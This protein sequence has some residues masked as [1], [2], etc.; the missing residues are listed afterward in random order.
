MPFPATCLQ[1]SRRLLGPD[2]PCTTL[3]IGMPAITSS[4]GQHLMQMPIEMFESF[5][6]KAMA[7]TWT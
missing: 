6:L 7:D 3:P 5:S 2:H 4:M 1:L